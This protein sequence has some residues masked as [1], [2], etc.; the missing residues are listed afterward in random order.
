MHDRPQTWHYGLVARFWAEFNVAGP[1]IACYQKFI[2]SVGQPAL[3]VACEPGRLML[4]G[5]SA[6]L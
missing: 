5:R 3:D 4:S 1:E 6:C 2:E